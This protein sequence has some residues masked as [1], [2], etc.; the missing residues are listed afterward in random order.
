MIPAVQWGEDL[1]YW[2]KT[3][4][5][6]NTSGIEK[7]HRFMGVGEGTNEMPEHLLEELRKRPIYYKSEAPKEIQV[8]HAVGHHTYTQK[9]RISYLLLVYNRHADILCITVGFVLEKIWLPVLFM[10]RLYQ[11]MTSEDP[12]I[13]KTLPHPH[14]H[15]APR[16]R[17]IRTKNI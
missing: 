7:S 5:Q 10:V 17:Q 14:Q 3:N 2:D 15:L 1:Y 9:C 8:S 12:S 6:F 16:R 4:V 13:L 11:G